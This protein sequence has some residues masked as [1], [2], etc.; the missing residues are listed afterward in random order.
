M[1]ENRFLKPFLGAELSPEER[2]LVLEELFVFGKENQRPFL[3]RMAMLIMVS[4]VIATG[5]LLSDS[6]AV[7]IGAMLVAPMMRPVMAA[8]AAIVLGWAKR[9]YESLLLVLAMT[10]GV[11]AIAAVITM[12]SPE[13]ITIPRQVLA[14]TEPT[15][16]DLVIALAA[17]V[18]GAY[19]M[20]RKES[21]AIPGVAMAVSLLPPLA[22]CGILIVFTEYNFA[23]KA[24]VLF[25]TN[26]LAM[27]LAGAVTFLFAGI[28]TNRSSKTAGAFRRNYTLVFI[29]LVGAISV[30]LWHYS[31][32]QWYGSHYRAAKSEILQTWLSDNSLELDDVYIDEQR[33][34]LY[35]NL[36]GAE[37]PLSIEGLHKAVQKDREKRGDHREFT[38]KIK[39]TQ[40]IRSSWPPPPNITDE[41]AFLAEEH[42]TEANPLTG[43]VWQWQQTQYSTE[44]WI[45]SKNPENYII[46]FDDKDKVTGKVSCNTM[47]AS[48]QLGTNLLNILKVS[49]SRALCKNPDL[50]A[51]FIGDLNRVIDFEIIEDRLVLQLNNNAGLMYFN[52]ADK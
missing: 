44:Q 10:I 40:T 21:S 47:K 37:P 25:V 22:S 17:G 49:S 26:F 6:A 24:F 31:N 4:T 32:A 29:I 9:L 16:F 18:G 35:L 41:P 39:W 50:D 33:Q 34:I 46:T 45:E 30:P 51:A 12:L 14:R 48:Y 52:K 8:A 5:G 43:K 19:V 7:V 42:T 20:T 36:F 15:F 1:A 27:T 38:I 2:K 3:T 13:M 11:V 23:V 28:T